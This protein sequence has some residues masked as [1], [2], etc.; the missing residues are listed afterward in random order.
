MQL[1]ETGGLPSRRRPTLAPHHTQEGN[2]MARFIAAIARVLAVDEYREPEVHFH[3]QTDRPEVC[4]D[5][6]CAR[7]RLNLD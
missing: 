4:Y 6:R 7:P 5:E 2:D 3:A 1:E